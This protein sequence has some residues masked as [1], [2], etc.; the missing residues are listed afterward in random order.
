MKGLGPAAVA[1]SEGV[2]AEGLVER[3]GA[4]KVVCEKVAL[5]KGLDTEGAMLPT[6]DRL[7]LGSTP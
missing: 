3:V 6:A 4:P 5:A 2:K 1:P 7:L